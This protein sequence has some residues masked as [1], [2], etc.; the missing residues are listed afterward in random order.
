MFVIPIL[1]QA[2]VQVLRSFNSSA[3]YQLCGFIPVFIN[4]KIGYPRS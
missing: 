4:E 3:P 2:L 1:G